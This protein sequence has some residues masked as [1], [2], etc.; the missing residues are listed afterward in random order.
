[1]RSLGWMEELMGVDMMEMRQRKLTFALLA[2]MTIFAGCKS[3]SPTTPSVN[4][5]GTPGGITPPT[6]ANIVLTVSNANPLVNSNV[7]VTA[8][9]TQNNQPVPNG[10]AVQF[11]TNLGTFTDTGGTQTVRIT[12]NGVA[13]ATLT[14]ATAGTAIVT[15][16]VN[17]VSKQITVTFSTQPV[18]PPP[19]S[20][21]PTITSIT[22][23]TGKPQG[24]DVV[25]ITGT[26]FTGPIRVLFDLG[27]G[28]LKEGFVCATCFTSTT[29]TVV[30]PAVDIAQGTA[31]PADVIVLT[32]AGTAAEQRA[33]KAAGFTFTSATLTPVIL[34]LSPTSGPI[35][36]GT[37]VTI[38]GNNFQSPV[39]VFFNAA[40]A[41]LI[42]VTFSQIIVMSPRASDTAPT[43]SGVVTGPVDV[44]VRN[45]NSN[46]E[47]TFSG[48]FRYIPG[49]QI[50]AFAPVVGTALGGTQVRIDGSGFD[51]PVS[52]IIGGV[53]AQPIRVS[54]TEIIAVTNPTGSPCS[55]AT[56]PVVVTNV[57]NGDTA[58]STGTFS[59]LPVKPVI[60]SV[61]SPITPG[62]TI[63]V[64]VQ[65]PGIGPLGGA[66][67]RFTLGGQTI[68]PT[69]SAISIGT[70]VQ[71]FT[72]VV[73]PATAFNFPL[74]ACGMGGQNLGPVTS[75]L[76][77]NNIT[78]SCTDSID[79]TITPNP[80]TNPCPPPTATVT[81]PPN[82]CPNL[83][84]PTVSIAT[85][86]T[87]QTATITIA[88]ATNSQTLVLG[89]PVVTPAG[90]ATQ[91]ATI[92]PVTGSNVNGGSSV[93]Y[94]VT[95]IPTTPGTTGATITFTSNDP[96]KPTITITVC[97][98]ATP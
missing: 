30:T 95:V 59:F 48:G 23:N 54:G 37:R 18:Q 2:L 83:T 25:T 79:V 74:V 89:P 57:N 3:E 56:G 29:I 65:N 76:T 40:E 62:G 28:T 49:L 94:T 60:T 72:V 31:Q 34:A 26:N 1:M 36:G 20:T 10:T 47:V 90:T 8:T 53:P 55:S 42:S 67:I 14:S 84:P 13:T 12:T 19:P 86:P 5:G 78:T 58:T 44:K 69:P 92:S 50:N 15:A 38:I 4:T 51:D 24:G 98:T 75:S 9:V 77:F 97:G 63:T 39:Q 81:S 68:V 52:V 80:A 43:G 27:N 21:T 7:I 35:G 71:T 33:T 96:T 11:I 73:P 6:N 64:G 17:N 91:T 87:N 82:T 61:S 46:K 93:S 22:P 70:G 85:P 16:T 41:Q 32:Q 88:N 66:N 45:I